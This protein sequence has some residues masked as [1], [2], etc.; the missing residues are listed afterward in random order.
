MANYSKSL[1]SLVPSI[2]SARA[3][4]SP[5]TTS[6][7]TLTLNSHSHEHLAVLQ[8]LQ[9]LARERFY[10]TLCLEFAKGEISLVKTTASVRPWDLV[11]AESPA[12]ALSTLATGGVEEV[13][14]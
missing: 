9:R 1:S 6:T 2:A 3:M 13:Q 10:G 5:G 7:T 4:R 8:Y 14:Q 11:G 12:V